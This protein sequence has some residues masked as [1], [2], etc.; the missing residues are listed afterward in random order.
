MRTCSPCFGSGIDPADA[1]PC[2]DCDGLGLVASDPW[3]SDARRSALRGLADSALASLRD[4]GW[5]V[6]SSLDRDGW[7]VHVRRGAERLVGRPARSI[8][9]AI[10]SACSRGES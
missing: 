1:M 8:A 2:P 4:G 7:T 6:L 5:R 9:A 10:A 3:L